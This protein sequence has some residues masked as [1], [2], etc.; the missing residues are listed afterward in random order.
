LEFY[1]GTHVQ[2]ELN[3][4]FDG[5][6]GN[7]FGMVKG[8]GNDGPGP[9]IAAMLASPAGHG[10]SCLKYQDVHI[11]APLWE[12]SLRF[13]DE[14]ATRHSFNTQKNHLIRPL[15]NAP[16]GIETRSI[17]EPSLCTKQNGHGHAPSLVLIDLTILKLL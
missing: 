11:Q 5:I 8:A 10:E 7:Y 1:L 14:R 13:P 2:G 6:D 9:E 16:I 17:F 4:F 12:S 15:T 3:Q